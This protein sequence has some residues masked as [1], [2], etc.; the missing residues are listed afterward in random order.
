MR[1]PFSARGDVPEKTNEFYSFDAAG[2]PIKI[3]KETGWAGRWWH[4][5]NAQDF[6]VTLM[7]HAGRVRSSTSGA[8]SEEYDYDIFTIGAGSGGVRS[9]RFAASYGQM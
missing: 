2:L 1:A 6:G 7:S 9:S 8:S 3:N 5:M 4:R